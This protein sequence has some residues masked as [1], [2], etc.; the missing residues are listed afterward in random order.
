MSVKKALVIIAICMAIAVPLQSYM[1]ERR[2]PEKS[3]GDVLYLPSGETVKSLSF[4]FDGIL[5][6]IYWLRSVQYFGRQLL[7]NKNEIDFSLMS[8]V[9]YDLLYPLLDITTTL[10][11]YYIA[12]YRFGAIFLPD[13]NYDQALQLVKKGIYHNPN[14]WHLYHNLATLYW[15]KKDYKSASETFLKGAELPKAPLWM[16][17]MGG[18]M[19]SEGGSRSTACKM[20]VT[21]Y[22]D[23]VSSKDDFVSKQME[24]QIKRIYA[25]DEVDY[26]NEVLARFRQIN[27]RC[28][29]SIEELAPILRR[30]SGKTGSCGQPIAIKFNN[31]GEAESPIGNNYLYDSEQCKIKLPIEL[32]EL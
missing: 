12:P 31:K 6:D 28:P 1:D 24:S 7:N 9:R 22:E 11:P 14:N 29:N 10:D 17:I 32:D 15:E 2:P 16:R 3:I 27:N 4:G 23:A 19:L 13:Y 20:Y 25:L 5:A 21:I 8:Q 26:M 30:N 18:V